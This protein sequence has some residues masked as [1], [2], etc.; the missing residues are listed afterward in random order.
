MSQSR[1]PAQVGSNDGLGVSRAD[2]QT[3][4]AVDLALGLKAI[5]I[6]LP[7]DLLAAYKHEAKQRGVPYQALMRDVLTGWIRG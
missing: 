5:S 7:R 2:S 3:E 4:A 1:M 6:R